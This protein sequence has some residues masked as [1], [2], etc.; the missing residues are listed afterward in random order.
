MHMQMNEKIFIYMPGVKAN[1]G[2]VEVNDHSAEEILNGHGSFFGNTGQWQNSTLILTVANTISAYTFVQIVVDRNVIGDPGIILPIGGVSQKSNGLVMS[3]DVQAG[4]FHTPFE[5]VQVVSGFQ[6]SSFML[7]INSTQAIECSFKY[8]TAL[9]KGQSIE[10][11]LAGLKI[12]STESV[13]TFSS[14]PAGLLQTAYIKDVH[15]IVMELLKPVAAETSFFVQFLGV[16]T[17]YLGSDFS[18]LEPA[19]SL[20]GE[21]SFLPFYSKLILFGDLTSSLRTSSQVENIENVKV[22]DA[23]VNSVAGRLLSAAE[24]HE[25]SPDQKNAVLDADAESDYLER[26][27]QQARLSAAQARSSVEASFSQKKLPEID[28]S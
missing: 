21:T 24:E 13:M 27:L 9:N 12:A 28:F 10:L 2:A 20:V 22:D 11:S 15:N 26:A 6:N 5:S 23:E 4:T 8:S 25:P 19:V 17:L 1:G 3:I 18:T 14:T 7:H 16:S